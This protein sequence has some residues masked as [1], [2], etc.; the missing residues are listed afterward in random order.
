MLKSTSHTLLF[1]G[2]SECILDTGFSQPIRV[3]ARE[4][5][6]LLHVFLACVDLCGLERA[7]NGPF[8]RRVKALQEY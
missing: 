4:T 2:S 8:S 7:R 3:L 1:A 5:I 6:R